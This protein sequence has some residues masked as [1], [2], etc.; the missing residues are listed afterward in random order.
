MSLIVLNDLFDNH[1]EYF[2]ALHS[3][4]GGQLPDNVTLSSGPYEATEEAFEPHEAPHIVQQHPGQQ[5]S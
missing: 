5:S 4:S 3:V 2:S 1:D